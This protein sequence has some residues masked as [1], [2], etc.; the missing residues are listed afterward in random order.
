MERIGKGILLNKIF[1][2]SLDAIIVTDVNLLICLL[3]TE[4]KIFIKRH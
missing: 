2:S 1:K 3:L 4:N